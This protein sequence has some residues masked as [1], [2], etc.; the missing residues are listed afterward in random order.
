MTKIAAWLVTIGAAA[1]VFTLGF[2][3]FSHFVGY[4]SS[5]SGGY[6]RKHIECPAPVEVLLLAAEPD[7]YPDPEVCKPP[8]RTLAL[9]A[10]LVALATTAIVWQPLRRPDPDPIGRL[11]DRINPPSDRRRD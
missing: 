2:T 4:E 3:S 5:G 6:V 9:E 1:I 11:S 8:A 10:A 7:D